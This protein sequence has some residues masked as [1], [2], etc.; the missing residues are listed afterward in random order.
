MKS[1]AKAPNST[2]TELP[3]PAKDLI[4]ALDQGTTGN[5]ALAVDRDLKVVGRGYATFPQHFPEPGWVEHDGDELWAS[6]LAALKQAMEGLDPSR[7]AALG[8]T[9]QRETTFALD[10]ATMRPVHRAIVWQDRRTAD[11]CAAMKDQEPQIR[12]A[13]GL[14]LDPY[15][16]ATKL[17][18]LM[19]RFPGRDLAFA[20]ADT[21]LILRLSGAYATDAS[22]ASRTQLFD[23]TRMAWSDDLRRR[24]QV[25][26]ARLPEIVPSAGPFAQVRGVPGLPDGLPIAGLAGDQQAALF[27]QGCFDAGQAKITYGTGSFVLMNAGAAIPRSRHGLLSTM[28]W[29]LGA[30][31]RYALEGG[32]FMAGALVQWM[33][34]G[35][36]LLH[37]AA[38]SEALARSVPDSGGVIVIP[39]HAGLGAPHWRP[40]ARG[41]ILGLTRGSTAAH[42]ARAALE[43]I[44]HSQADILEAMAA[45]LGSPLTE[46]RV[47]GGAAA[48]DFLMQTQADLL[49]IPLHRPKLL[50]T[51]ALGAAMLAGLG[52][53]L[54]AMDELRRAYPLDKTFTPQGDR[55]KVRAAR[56]AW[57]AAVA[58]A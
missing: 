11:R 45:D 28:A 19:D 34:D 18:W 27:G 47:D 15:F 3:A 8:L 37:D 57:K 30:D 55:A 39:A 6:A 13:T 12:E 23:L 4:L 52:V 56:A 50:E 33:R 10:A 17:R 2:R 36:G 44:A 53:G 25:E 40:E 9:N 5:T 20:T 43:G 49:G 38:E 54:W 7:F 29:D 42:V 24:F 35:L 16:S 48:N 41:A 31:P 14:P 1:S 46:L 51:T 21:H 22:N 26:G 32:A 58:K